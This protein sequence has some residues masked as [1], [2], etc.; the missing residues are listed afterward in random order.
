MVAAK[1]KCKSGATAT[2]K[3]CCATNHAA[4][5]TRGQRT[6]STTAAVPRHKVVIGVIAQECQGLAQTLFGQAIFLIPPSL[7]LKPFVEPTGERFVLLG[8]QFVQRF[9]EPPVPPPRL[10]AA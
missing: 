8:S 10:V 9:S 7:S 4:K 3:A 5:T 1:T 2:K 6:K